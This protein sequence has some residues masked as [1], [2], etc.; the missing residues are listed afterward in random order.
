MVAQIVV[1]RRRIAQCALLLLDVPVRHGLASLHQQR[2]HRADEQ[3]A[4]AA[5]ADGQL[6]R[7]GVFLA[8]KVLGRGDEV[9]EDVLLPLLGARQVPR[10]AELPAAY[11]EDL[12][13]REALAAW[14]D[15]DHVVTGWQIGT[16]T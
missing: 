4:V 6:R 8:N 7:R 5:A 3:A 15:D 11:G 13:W 14:A 1:Q 12:C 9:V 10:L 2:D 16:V